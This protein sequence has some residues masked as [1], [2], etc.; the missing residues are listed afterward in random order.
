MIAAV[1]EVQL[2]ESG[3]AEVVGLGC[4]FFFGSNGV[5]RPQSLFASKRGPYYGLIEYLGNELM[6]NVL[7]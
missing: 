3:S 7:F 1:E 2:L 6:L 4:R 5:R